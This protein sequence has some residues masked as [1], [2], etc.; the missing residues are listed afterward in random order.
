VGAGRRTEREEQ[1]L[2]EHETTT[3]VFDVGDLISAYTGR[4]V[5]REHM[6]GVHRILDHLTGDTLFTHQLPAAL[7]AVAPALV[8]QHP[9]LAEVAVPETVRD[10]ATAAAFVDEMAAKYGAGH[11]VRPVPEVWGRHD[12]L[13]DLESMLRPDQQ[14]VVVVVPDGASRD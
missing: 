8:E 7:E 10:D 13:A 6:S 11:V 1:V 3:A 9:W 4:L 2:T 12:P 14:V 5:S